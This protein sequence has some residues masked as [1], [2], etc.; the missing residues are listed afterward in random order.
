M[1]S[2]WVI[3]YAV[4]AFGVYVMFD[5]TTP[6]SDLPW[7]FYFICLLVVLLVVAITMKVLVELCC[8]IRLWLKRRNPI[9]VAIRKKKIDQAPEN[10][11]HCTW[12][13]ELVL[14]E[15]EERVLLIARFRR[16]A[17]IKE[18]DV[19]LSTRPRKTKGLGE[20]KI[21]VWDPAPKNKIRIVGAK[22]HDINETLTEDQAG[23]FHKRFP[24]E[25][26]YERKENE[27][28]VLIVDISAPVEWNG[29]IGLR[30]STTEKEDVFL[31]HLPV[32]RLLP[33]WK[34]P[35][36]GRPKPE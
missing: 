10:Q 27:Q 29:V 12:L 15:A 21:K 17:K 32:S 24:S 13:Y 9:I 1:E 6:L 28:L 2:Q 26:P 7:W 8:W 36:Q 20:Q 33:V 31:Y 16:A 11:L 35:E 4:L 34:I 22:Q 19:R 23:G 25:S 5:K 3:W 30:I 14:E 18:Y